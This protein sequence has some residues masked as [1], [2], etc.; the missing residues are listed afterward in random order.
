M[1]WFHHFVVAVDGQAREVPE[2]T[3]HLAL[4]EGVNRIA[5]TPVNDLGRRGSTALLTL[6]LA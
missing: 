6:R 4:H 3:F 2:D 5:V 1:P